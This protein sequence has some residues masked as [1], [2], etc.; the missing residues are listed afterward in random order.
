MIPLRKSNP[1]L[2]IINHSPHPTPHFRGFSGPAHTQAT[3]TWALW[4]PAS[5]GGLALGSSG[6][7]E[8]VE[9]VGLYK[10]R[11]PAGPASWPDL[12]AVHRP[13]EGHWSPPASL[14]PCLSAK[15]RPGLPAMA[16]PTPG[17]GALPAGARGRGR[18]RRLV[19]TPS[20]R[21]ALRACFERNP[22]P[23]IATREELAQAIG[24]P[25]PRVQIW[26]QNERSRQLRQHRR[27]S[28][29]WPGKRGPQEG[30]RKRTAVTRSQTAL[31]LRAFQ[32]DRFPGIA[33][34]EELAR[35]TGL[36]ESRIQIWFQNRRARHPGQGGGAPAHAGGPGDAA[37]GGCPPAPSPVAFTHTG[38]WATGLPAPHVPCAPWTLP[39]GAFVGQGAGAVAPLQPSQAAQA[40]GIS[41][42]APAGGDWDFSYAALA[43]PEG[44]LS[45]PQTPRGW[46]PRPSQ[47]RGDRG[48]QHHSLPGPCSVGQPGPAGAEPQGQGVL[49]PPTSQ[50]SP[51]WGW[52]QGPQVAGAAWE[53]QVGAAPPPGPAPPEASAGQEQMQAIRAPSPPL[54][55]PGRSSALPCSLLDELLETPEFLQQGQ[56]LLE[57]E[58]PTELQDVGEPALL[59]P[60]LLSDE[61][62]RALLEEL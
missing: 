42:P 40:A 10:G 5:E 39:P 56:P 41:H 13:T 27:E 17:D 12:L 49:A 46:P 24:I 8:G 20:Q 14:C 31:L 43:T 53:P 32:Q 36:P 7:P 22:Y 28:R 62:Y 55:E 58:A 54:Q 18:R 19:W 38:A 50:G 60:L 47:W 61:E 4:V 21:E 52:G 59:E 34:R 48:P 9:P 57:T 16:L 37:P 11:W 3:V 30:R 2:K 23:G 6:I 45:H 51:W 15:F 44:A 35:E 26:F 1:I 33:T 25:E 29:P